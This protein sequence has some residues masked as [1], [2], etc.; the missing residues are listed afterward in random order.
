MAHFDEKAN[1]FSPLAISLTLEDFSVFPWPSVRL[2]FK[3]APQHLPN[4]SPTLNN[5][6]NADINTR[7][8]L[9]ANPQI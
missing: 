5:F 1:C 7:R 6:S 8:H 9:T 3:S 2:I 4:S